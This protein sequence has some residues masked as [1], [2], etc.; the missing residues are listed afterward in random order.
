MKVAILASG[1]GSNFEAIVKA[2]EKGKLKGIKVA[3]L[4][5]DKKEAFVRKRAQ[6]HKIKDIFIDPKNFKNRVLFDKY[7]VNILKKENIELVILAGFMRIL[8][9]YFVKVFKNRILNIHPAL[10]PAFKGVDA[11]KRAYNY[12][13]KVTGVTIHFVNEDVDCGPIILQTPLCIREGENLKNLEKRI[14]KLEHKLY[15]E[16]IK[17]FTERKLKIKKRKVIISS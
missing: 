10:L 15:P 7:I 4:I 9:P 1:N 2:V 3:L 14:H 5:T 16:A 13:V 8:S 6:K 12:G 11:I 17:L